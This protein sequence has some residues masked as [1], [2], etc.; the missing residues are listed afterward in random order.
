MTAAS[1][2]RTFLGLLDQDE[3]DIIRR[4]GLID[5][6]RFNKI[7]G[8][9]MTLLAIGGPMSFTGNDA[10]KN[11]DKLSH[12]TALM[13]CIVATLS[14]FAPSEVVNSVLRNVLLDL[15]QAS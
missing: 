2:D 13:V 3:L 9:R 7:W 5:I 11:L 10:E 14:A 8:S 4:K 12:F 1:G 15:F 6:L